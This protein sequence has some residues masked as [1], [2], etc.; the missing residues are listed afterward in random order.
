MR[1]KNWFAFLIKKKYLY[2][3]YYK[4]K[5]SKRF[6][7]MIIILEVVSLN[8]LAFWDS[9]HLLCNM[10]PKHSNCILFQFQNIAVVKM[11]EIVIIMLHREYVTILFYDF[12][13]SFTAIRKVF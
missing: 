1:N 3:Y 10:V 13:I 12:L 6:L 8:C 2:T 7:F 5:F 9:Q 4:F 11:F